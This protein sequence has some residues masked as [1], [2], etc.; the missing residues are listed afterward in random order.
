M[1]ITNLA[2]NENAWKRWEEKHKDPILQIKDPIL[3]REHKYRSTTM[4]K[5]GGKQAECDIVS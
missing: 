4:H 1:S 5:L 3:H 2:A